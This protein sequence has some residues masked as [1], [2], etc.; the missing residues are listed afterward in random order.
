VIAPNTEIAYLAN[1]N[2]GL[3][4]DGRSPIPVAQRPV[5]SEPVSSGDAIL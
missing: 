4:M 5:S 2:P 1:A 3:V